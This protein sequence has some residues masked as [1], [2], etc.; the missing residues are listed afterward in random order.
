MKLAIFYAAITFSAPFAAEGFFVMQRAKAGLKV[1][2][3]AENDY[4][5][6]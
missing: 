6:I 4:Y 5:K 3:I 2:S 1:D